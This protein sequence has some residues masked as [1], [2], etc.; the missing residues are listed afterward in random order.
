[1]GSLI[2]SLEIREGELYTSSLLA[3]GI[4]I[5][6]VLWLYKEGKLRLV[7]ATPLVDNIGPLRTYSTLLGVYREHNPQ[8]GI[9]WTDLVAISPKDNIITHLKGLQSSLGY[10]IVGRMVRDQYTKGGFIKEAYILLLK[11]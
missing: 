7:I 1:M 11:A 10:P 8:L 3:R 6:A 5:E 2:N 9:E 4:P